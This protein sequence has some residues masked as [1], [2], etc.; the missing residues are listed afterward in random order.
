MADLE[1]R[2][3]PEAVLIGRLRREYILPAASPARVDGLGGNLA[4]AAA[5]FASWGGKAG[6]VARVNSEFPLEWLLP[7]RELG[8]LTDGVHPVEEPLDLR[9]F[10]AYG[11]TNQAYL[12]NPVTHFAERQLS[13][14]KELL[15]Y[16]PRHE[17]CSKT[18]YESDS[19][20][21][22][23]MP[24]LFLEAKFA[25]VCPIDFIS[26]KI[27]PSVLKAGMIQCLTMRACSCYMDPIFWEEIRGLI[28]DLTVFMMTET[29]ALK[30]FQGRRV[31]LWEIA[32]HLAG[33][34]PE[35]VLVQTKEGATRLFDRMGH[36]RWILPAYSVRVSDP[37]GM[38]DAFDGGFLAGFKKTR[39]P[40]EAALHGGISA[41]IA[42]EGSGPYFI[43]DCLP[44]LK[45]MRL[46][47]L[48][49]Q[50][51]AA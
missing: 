18:D 37:T 42:G 14:P 2:I 43:L 31:D 46:Q 7:L 21:V 32:E 9:R 4:Y 10:V 8:F 26:H 49:Q 25:H 1:V 47:V 44:G 15:G 39:D 41:A 30:L 35:V 36:K 28:A 24:R 20:R 48:R 12:D 33:Y 6:L 23:D 40:L 16:Q 17:Y 22:T 11:E 50:V 27:L 13:F 45:E 51:I 38:N 5:A 29:Q 3:V 34:G 19:F